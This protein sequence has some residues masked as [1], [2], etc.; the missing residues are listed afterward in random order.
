MIFIWEPYENP[1]QESVSYAKDN[2][3]SAVK[4]YH[5]VYPAAEVV[6]VFN[7]ETEETHI[8]E[9]EKCINIK[10]TVLGKA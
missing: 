6:L 7:D 2:L 1:R 4:E 5:K 9:I 3:E 10:S 8:C